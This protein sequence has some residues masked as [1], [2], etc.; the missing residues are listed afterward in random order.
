MTEKIKIIYIYLYF[1]TPLVIKLLVCQC[2]GIDFEY[3]HIL[4]MYLLKMYLSI[5][6]TVQYPQYKLSLVWE[7]EIFENYYY[8]LSIHNFK[9]ISTY[10]R[11]FKHMYMHLQTHATY[12]LIHRCVQCTYILLRNNGIDDKQ[13][14]I[15]Q[16]SILKSD[17]LDQIDTYLKM[18]CQLLYQ[19]CS[20][21]LCKEKFLYQ[22]TRTLI[23]PGY[24]NNQLVDVDLKYLVDFYSLLIYY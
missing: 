8:Y 3:S 16:Q 22:T 6:L 17:Q 2:R 12:L 24:L 21:N 4:C 13:I 9:R 20:C 14:E 19:Q 1:R 23:F 5:L 7:C 18:S 15:N 10:I 11:I